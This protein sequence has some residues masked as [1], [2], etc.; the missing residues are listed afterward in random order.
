LARA[1]LLGDQTKFTRRARSVCYRWF[2]DS[3]SRQIYPTD[4]HAKY[5]RV[6]TAQLRAVSTREGTGSR[7]AAL[8]DGLL[9][10]S[11]EFSELW[12]E[13]EIGVP[14]LLHP[15]GAE[16]SGTPRLWAKDA[17]LSPA[18][19]GDTHARSRRELYCPML[20]DPEQPQTLLIYTAI[21]GTESD[22]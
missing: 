8:V 20:L 1:V 18:E 6:F 2:T 12:G 9:D 11:R 13:H 10:R 19:A 15:K 4:E 5:G 16:N 21:P 14:R 7:A 17:F 3:T 22:E